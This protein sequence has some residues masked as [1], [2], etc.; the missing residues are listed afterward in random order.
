MRHYVFFMRLA[1]LVALVL[2]SIM[3]AGWKWAKIGSRL[4]PRA[5]SMS[6]APW[7]TMAVGANV[8]Q[9]AFTRTPASRNS[10]AAVAV[11]EMAAALVAQ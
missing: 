9:T 3:C 10:Q 8:G 6:G 5:T 7:A 11:S 4:V 1:V 2:A